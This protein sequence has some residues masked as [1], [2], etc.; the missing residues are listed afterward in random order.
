MK[1]ILINLKDWFGLQENIN[2]KNG[3]EG[4]PIVVFPSLPYLSIY[5]D[6]KTTA[7][8]VQNVFTDKD[9]AHTGSVSLSHLKDFNI[10]WAI[11]NHK[12][13]EKEPEEIILNKIIKCHENNI[14]S[15][16]C[17]EKI[18]KAYKDLLEKV[19]LLEYD[20]VYIAYEPETDE[21]LEE[22]K[23]NLNQIRTIVSKIPLI[24][25]G[26]IKADNLEELEKELCV[27][28]FLI[29]RDALESANLK[30][31]LNSLK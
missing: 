27:F 4:Y 23:H 22:V 26:N 10:T 14:N 11:I 1:K 5:K 24:Y 7:I 28:G 17:I 29:S 8:G 9:G 30:K 31:I 25:G 6:L 18:D 20:D 3:V 13:Q 12:E 21:N 2:F 19:Q 15:I 16:L